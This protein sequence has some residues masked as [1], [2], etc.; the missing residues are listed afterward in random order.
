[1]RPAPDNPQSASRW[2]TGRFFYLFLCPISFLVLFTYLDLPGSRMIFFRLLGVA[3]FVSG[4]DALSDKRAEWGRA[5]ILAIPAGV[6][7]AMV[8]WRP[9]A[10]LIVPTLISTILFLA[11][12]TVLP[13]RAVLRSTTLKPS[14]WA[15]RATPIIGWI[16]PTIS[17]TATSRS[18]P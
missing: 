6:I 4:V 3:A 10:G 8:A 17:S 9:G 2:L 7:N 12:T 15:E 18:P 16:G 5:L 1:M 14:L 11:F 13:L